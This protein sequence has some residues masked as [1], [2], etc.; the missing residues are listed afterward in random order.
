[1]D[2]VQESH[3]SDERALRLLATSRLIS[4]FRENCAA[5]ELYER[6]SRNYETL[7]G[8]LE[9]PDTARELESLLKMPAVGIQ[10]DVE[11]IIGLLLFNRENDPYLSLGFRERV[12]MTEA[13]RR[14]KRLMVLYHPDRTQDRRADRKDHEE[15]AKRI[16]EAYEEIV[17]RKER[18]SFDDI[19]R[20]GSI[21][22]IAGTYKP[23]Y[24]RYLKYLPTIIIVAVVIIA[25]I[26]I[27]LFIATL[28]KMI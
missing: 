15:K 7:L 8:I 2:R 13:N 9:D 20:E 5:R 24:H 3:S 25:L 18:S 19:V 6:A 12:S 14:W 22:G 28:K 4:L 10:G 1:M 21:D 23:S 26:S 27:L 16:N 11:A 17:K